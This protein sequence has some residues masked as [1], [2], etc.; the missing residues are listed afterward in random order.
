MKKII[1]LLTFSIFTLFSCSSNDEDNSTSINSSKLAD[2][3]YLKQALLDGKVVG[4]SNEIRFTTDK[5]AFFTYYKL[6]GNGQDIIETG[7]YSITG[8][9]ILITWDSSDPGNETDTFQIL[10]LTSEKLIVKSSDDEGTLVET[11]MK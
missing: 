9:T 3:W 11:Y 5:R 10:E 4:S 7:D 1:I 8:N 2:T 6:G